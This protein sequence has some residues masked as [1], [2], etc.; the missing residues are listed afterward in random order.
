[1]PTGTPKAIIDRLHREITG[2]LGLA[3]ARER[4]SGLG[5]DVVASTPAQFAAHIR[6]ELAVW[7]KVVKQ[8]G[9]HAD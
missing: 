1:M 8:S 4:I 9:I 6:K 7:D 5:A 3:D 2:V